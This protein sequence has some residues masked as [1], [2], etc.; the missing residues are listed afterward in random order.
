MVVLV[1]DIILKGGNFR[2]FLLHFPQTQTHREKM[3]T[4]AQR[5]DRGKTRG[6]GGIGVGVSGVFSAKKAGGGDRGQQQQQQKKNT[7][8]W[9]LQNIHWGGES[10]PNSQSGVSAGSGKPVVP[11]EKTALVAKWVKRIENINNGD[12]NTETKAKE[13]VFVLGGGGGGKK[14]KKLE[15]VKRVAYDVNVK[16]N[17]QRAAEEQ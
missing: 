6:V 4:R 16:R 12:Y 15:V 11:Q 17:Q 3:S 7:S 10:L 14:R 13:D 2:G 8:R 1:F 9:E 5:G